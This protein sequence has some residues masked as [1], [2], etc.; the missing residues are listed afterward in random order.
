MKKRNDHIWSPRGKGLHKKLLSVLLTICITGALAGCST[1]PTA[2]TA[3]S[4]TPESAS[5]TPAAEAPQPADP[6]A[7]GDGSMTDVGTPRNQTLVV[8]MLSGRQANPNIM[9]PFM[10]GCVAMDVGVHQLIYSNLW[11]IDTVKGEQYPDLA[12]TMPEAVEGKEN[13]YTFKMKE[14]LK[15]SDGEALDAHDVAYTFNMLLESQE[16]TYGAV[17]RET[18][19]SCQALDDLTVSISQRLL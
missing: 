14:N 15:W 10:P 7:V 6:A 1:T 12:A 5:E 9:N 3:E 11:E 19:K 18:V 2:P 16:L 4:S 13:T 8:D 17:V